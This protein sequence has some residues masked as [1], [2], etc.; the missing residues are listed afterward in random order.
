MKTQNV[1]LDDD[2]ASISNTPNNN[3]LDKSLEQQSNNTSMN[4]GGFSQLYDSSYDAMN[5]SGLN[6]S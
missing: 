4:A 1:N 3:K 6:T 5:N 2:S